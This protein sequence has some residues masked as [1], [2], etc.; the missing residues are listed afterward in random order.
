MFILITLAVCLV[1]YPFIR[2]RMRAMSTRSRLAIFFPAAIALIAMQVAYTEPS[3][4]WG[5]WGGLILYGYYDA[6]RGRKGFL[7]EKGTGL[8]A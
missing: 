8:R 7:Q 2:P 6:M 4:R 3:W 1:L 5:V